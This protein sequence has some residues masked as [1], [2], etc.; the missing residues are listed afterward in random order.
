MGG[1]RRIA[2]GMGIVAWMWAAWAVAAD[3][4]TWRLAAGGPDYA[5]ERARGDPRDADGAALML[6]ADGVPAARFGSSG[7]R[8]PAGAFVGSRVRLSADL[9]T[10]QAQGRAGLWLRVDGDGGKRLGFANSLAQPL[11]PGQMAERELMLDVVEG[12]RTI[13]LGTLLEGQGEVRATSLRLRPVQ[14]PPGESAQAIL[15][16]AL[17]AIREHAL[18]ASRIDWERTERELRP[19]VAAMLPLQA[20]AELRTLLRQLGDGHSFVLDPGQSRQRREQARSAP[21]PQVEADAEGIGRIVVPGFGSP[22]EDIEQAFVRALHEGIGK[23]A[24]RAQC[25]WILDLRGN[26][27]GD[28]WPMLAGLRPLLGDADLG[29]FEDRTGR[30]PPWRAGANVAM[31]TSTSPDLTRAPVAVLHGPHTSSSGEIVAIAFHGRERTRSFGQPTSGQTTGNLSFELP[32]GGLLAV[33]ATRDLDRG[34]RVQEGRLQPDVVIDDTVQAE[35]A[36]VDWLVGLGCAAAAG[37]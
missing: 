6:R 5:V 25:G 28:M 37:N 31:A 16:V 29:F 20:Y 14:R 35:R 10:T 30:S 24:P 13:L 3:A 21:L 34:G 22:D 32:G 17:P 1:A 27:G 7:F 12:A 4:A 15:D 36:A 26:G 9:L 23:V 33:A 18:H 8:L 11:P 19:R 2:A